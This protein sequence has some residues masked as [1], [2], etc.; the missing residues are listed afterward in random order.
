VYILEEYL[1]VIVLAIALG[2]AGT[3][4]LIL[5]L[6]LNEEEDRLFEHALP[7]GTFALPP[8]W[9]RL[10]LLMTVAEMWRALSI[11]FGRRAKLW[12]RRVYPRP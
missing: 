7:T 10:W 2:V 12:W 1:A 3:A 9:P 5:V 4:M 11:S 6:P 8:Q